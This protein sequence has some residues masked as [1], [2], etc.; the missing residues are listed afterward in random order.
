MAE[1]VIACLIEK[2]I[3]AVASVSHSFLVKPVQDIH[4]KM[5]SI[6]GVLELTKGFLNH[7]RTYRGENDLVD[8]WAKLIQDVAYDIENIVNEYTFLMTSGRWAGLITHI[9]NDARAKSL[10]ELGKKLDERQASLS[11]LVRMKDSYGIRIPERFLRSPKENDLICHLAESALFVEEDDL[12]GIEEIKYKLIRLLTDEEPQ[13]TIISVL[14]MGGVGKT[15]LVARVCMD[16][17]VV[18]HFSCCAWISVSKSNTVDDLL[19]K[20]LKELHRERKEQITLD[21]DSM[22]YR[23]LVENLRLHLAHRR[24]L[25]ILDDVW[26]ADVWTDISYALYANNCRSRVVITTRVQDVSSLAGEERIVR[27]NPLPDEMAWD[28]FCKKAFP[29]EE[30]NICPQ[31]LT[32]WA[33]KMVD[34]C[35]GLPIAIAAI[36]N[37]LSHNERVES[38]WKKIHDSLTWST[39]DGSKELQKVPRILSLSIT[40]LPDHLRNCLMHCSLFPE[41]YLIA[42]NRLIRLW[43]A[44]GFVK[45]GGGMSME[46]V[47]EDYLNQLVGRSLLQV[48]DR[49]EL[50]R[51]RFCRVHDLVREIIMEKSRE[52]HFVDVLEGKFKDVSDQVQRLSIIKDYQGANVN[53]SMEISSLRSFHTFTPVPISVLLKCRLLRVLDLHAAPVEALPNAIGH[54]TNLQYLSIRK[55]N[56]KRLPNSLGG[57]LKLETLDAIYTNIEELPSGIKNL[58]N[59]RHL[60]VKKF[61]R[62]TSKYTILGGGVEV[63]G[64]VGNLKGLQTLKAVVAN[65]KMVHQLAKLTQMRSLDVRGVTTQLSFVLSS[66]LSKMDRLVR[67]VVM[68][69]HRDDTLLLRDMKPPPQLRTLNLYGNLDKRMLP[70]W[71]STLEN[72]THLVLKMSRLKEDPLPQLTALPNLVSLFLIQAYDGSKLQFHAHCF[73]R[74]R[75]LRLC[76]MNHLNCIEIEE[77]ALESLHEMTLVRCSQLKTIPVGLEHLTR[78]QKLEVEGMPIELV[79]KL[80]EGGETEEDSNRLKH[81][82]IIKNLLERDGIWVEDRLK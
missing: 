33:R 35:D 29:R 66:S 45:E 17:M 57:L 14:G 48:T 8:V 21:F 46:D 36:A 10:H 31:N 75:S 53:Q 5:N 82:P 2:I 12:V 62:Q 80:Q 63:P 39:N 49:N 72:L 56:V 20:I 69:R 28:L 38:T 19:K 71:F 65:D 1:A 60:M 47:A 4:K 34:K 25:I 42:R 50:G 11:K 37:L 58:G 24:Y 78:L 13:R 26:Q 61:H 41:D 7:A 22:D 68:A 30:G 55:T 27:V 52:E 73:D 77:N 9:N 51:V 43:V 76:D 64:G 70:P 3:T 74:L 23:T 16:I 44:E 40:N 67:L 15:T 59:L 32:Q 81:I 79:S 18:S 54:L 6:K